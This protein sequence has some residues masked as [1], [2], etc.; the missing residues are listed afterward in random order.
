MGHLN[1]IHYGAKTCKNHFANHATPF[2]LKDNHRSD[3]RKKEYR[4]RNANYLTFILGLLTIICFGQN[5][6]PQIEI[7]DIT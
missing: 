6:P 3:A 4:C 1:F 7:T 5:I 2:Q